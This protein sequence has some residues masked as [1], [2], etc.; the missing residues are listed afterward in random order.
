MH[1]SARTAEYVFRKTKHVMQEMR[2]YCVAP[3][4]SKLS[5]EDLQAVVERMYEIK[6]TKV[7]VAFSGVALKGMIERYQDRANILVRKDLSEDEKR[8]IA[9]KELCHVVNDQKEDFSPHGEATLET[10]L[11]AHQLENSEKLADREVQSEV[12]V[13]ISAIE[14]L[15]PHSF[16]AFDKEV[17]SRRGTSPS[18]LAVHFGVP[19]YIISRSLHSSHMDLCEKCWALIK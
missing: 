1:L 13:E 3:D 9:T 6:I 7:E 16:R 17:L 4:R 18:K 5:I 15:Y 12:F 2:T 14:L 19:E 8:F 11:Y 10:Y